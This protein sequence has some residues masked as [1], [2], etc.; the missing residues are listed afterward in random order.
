MLFQAADLTE[1]SPTEDESARLRAIF[2]PWRTNSAF[3]LGATAV[4]C[5]TRFDQRLGIEVCF[6]H[7]QAL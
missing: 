7:A 2:K 6:A 3:I 4:I 1:W 5:D